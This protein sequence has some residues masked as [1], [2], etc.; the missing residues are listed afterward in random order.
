MAEAEASSDAFAVLPQALVL[1]ILWRLPADS[2]LLCAA[3]CR[4]W[5]AAL[6]D[7][8]AWTRLDLSP[9]SGLCHRASDGLLRAA[10][11][12]ARGGLSFLD[13]SGCDGV[14]E[15]CL[16]AV[17]AD[18]AAS[19]TQL[20]AWHVDDGEVLRVKQV[21][22][23]LRAA[24][25]LAALHT[26]VFV[27]A[28]V[29]RA[30]LRREPPFGPLRLRALRVGAAED[31]A[32]VLALVDSVASHDGLE[33]LRVSGSTLSLVALDAVVDAA[34]ARPLLSVDLE[35][36]SLTAVSVPALARLLSPTDGR[37]AQLR[38]LCV[39]EGFMRTQ[40][41]GD[42]QAAAL[43]ADA[44]RANTT[45]ARL[46]LVGVGLW[47]LPA[48]AHTLLRACTGHA[49]LRA[50]DVSH[51]HVERKLRAEVGGALAALLA[52]DAPAL[53]ELRC[54]ECWLGDPGLEPLVG[55]LASNTHLHEL[56]VD[57]N[58][59]SESFADAVLL[60]ALRANA[61]LRRLVAVSDSDA[62]VRYGGYQHAKLAA[63]TMVSA[64][65][66]TASASA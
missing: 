62:D 27:S 31:D 46:A 37:P 66:Q 30:M 16:R 2:R 40:L 36:C 48:A 21:E 51:N 14:S 12:R 60:P 50:L 18:S 17:L 15:E 41:F 59:M 24:P 9:S 55:A 54:S 33:Q 64:R 20:R 35:D 11:A 49:S 22:A 65:W 1:H 13:V 56:H 7:P 4:G 19:L 32:A 34:K 10:T 26:N 43:L 45:L 57:D 25:H 61:S 58:R 39:Q 52:A 47:R 63:Q 42:F 38:S 3:V 6:A 53:R 29:A 28:A 8:R 44:L 5:R 23:L